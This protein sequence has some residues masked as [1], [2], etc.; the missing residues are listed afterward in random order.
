MLATNLDDS[1]AFV[2]LARQ[3]KA[4]SLYQMRLQGIMALVFIFLDWIF[5]LMNT[6]TMIPCG[7]DSYWELAIDASLV[8]C[9]NWKQIMAITPGLL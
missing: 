7:R 1:V 9:I 8:F 4:S 3:T 6:T 2:S 5:V